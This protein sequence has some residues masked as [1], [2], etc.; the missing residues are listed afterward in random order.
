MY[1]PYLRGKQFELLALKE[2]SPL[3]GA[4]KKT[5]PIIE[6]VRS[7]KGSGLDRCLTALNAEGLDFI[8]VMNPSVGALRGAYVAD[9]VATF[10]NEHP[11]SHSWNL[12]LLLFEDS[13]VATLINDYAST[14]GPGRRLTLIHR[15]V[16]QGLDGIPALT[17]ALQR[18]F[19]VIDDALRQRH[20]RELRKTTLGVTLHDWF[21]GEERNSAY[22]NKLESTFSEDHLYYQEEGW[23][24]F[25]DFLTIG[26]PYSDGG[27]TPRAVVIHW[28]Y[29]PAPGKPI[30][31]RHF[32]SES[33]AD[34]TNVG[35]K[36]LEAAGKLVTFLNAHDIHTHAAEVMRSHLEN[37]TY[38]GL[39][40]VK[41]LSIQNH[42]ELMSEILSR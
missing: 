23:Y 16:S 30:M 40:V 35:G 34:T 7:P 27:F 38:P 18:E 21:P 37:S 29:E 2:L 6:P 31:I 19:D 42:L 10:V 20:F 5:L 24:G 39:G 4:A 22:L 32:T 12:G 9:D 3:L 13:D 1:F 36:F 11:S 26:E 41:K 8:L 25:S 28:T 15:G 17:A 33:N 14:V